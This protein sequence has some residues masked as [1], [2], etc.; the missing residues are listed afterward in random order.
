MKHPVFQVDRDS[1]KDAGSGQ[2]GWNDKDSSIFD[3][4]I[5]SAIE[6]NVNV[7]SAVAPKAESVFENSEVGSLRRYALVR[8][9]NVRV[10]DDKIDKQLS[11][12]GEYLIRPYLERDEKIKFKYNFERVVS[13]DK[14]D[15]IFLI[16]E[17]CLYVIENFYVDDSGCICEKECANDLSVV[18]RVLSVTKDASLSIDSQSKSPLT[19]ILGSGYK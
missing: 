9:G 5:H 7:S 15:G 2:A 8:S 17:L 11:D 16:G 13:L 14:H 10:T 4:S 18:D 19:I 3:A 1:V 6:F 12:N